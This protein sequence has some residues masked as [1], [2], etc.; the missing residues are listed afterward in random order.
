MIKQYL[1]A[2]QAIYDHVGFKEDYVVYPIEDRTDMYWR[3]NS[4]YASWM[5]EI[6]E[7]QTGEK[8]ESRTSQ[9]VSFHE[10]R[11]AIVDNTGDQYEYEIYTQRLYN[12]W[13]YRGEKYTMI[14]C[15]SH[16]DG[17][18]YLSIFENEKEIRGT[19]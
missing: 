8:L 16:I 3:I 9:G 2:K 7:A 14:I 12:K 1:D 13:I 10:T 6:H 19:F 17:M 11:E 4:E 15:D 18:K 5:R